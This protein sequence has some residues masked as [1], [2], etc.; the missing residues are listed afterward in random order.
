MDP[1]RYSELFH[2]EARE[3]LGTL[4]RLLLELERDPERPGVV[5]QLF[6]SVHTLKGSSAAMG[7]QS[8]SEV[9]H[10]LEELLARLRQGSLAI[11]PT[12]IDLLLQGADALERAIEHPEEGASAVVLDRLAAYVEAGAP[13]RTAAPASSA[14]PAATPDSGAPTSAGP[15]HRVKVRLESDTALPAVRATLVLRAA[16]SLGEVSQIQPPEASILAGELQGPFAFVIHGEATPEQIEAAV[17]S[18]GEVAEVEV[19]PLATTEGEPERTRPREDRTPRLGPIVR[20]P[21]SR[22]DALVDQVGELIIARDRLRRTVAEPAEADPELAESLEGVSRLIDDLREE[23]MR[24]RMVPVGEVFDRFPRMVRDAARRLDR[25][26]ELEI[27]GREEEV[28]RGLLNE[29]ADLLVHLLRNAV[30][31]GIEPPEERERAGK[32]RVGRIRL[33]AIREASMVRIEV[34]DDG[35]GLQRERILATAVK[36]GLIEA[37]DRHLSDQEIWALLTTPGFSTSERV[38]DV[39]GRGVGLDMVRT[40]AQALGGSLEV[41]SEAGKGA[42]FTLRIPL[43]LTLVRALR[44]EAGGAYYSVPLSGVVEVAELVD[45]DGHSLQVRGETLPALDLRVLFA[46]GS[47]SP[48][49]ENVAVVVVEFGG[50]KAGLIVAA[51]EGQHQAVVKPVD[52]PEGALPIFGGATILP[53]GRPSLILDPARTVAFATGRADLSARA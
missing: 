26:V 11:G 16:R 43:S 38:T 47:G 1:S 37:P 7:Y 24:L 5:E 23:I 42:T 6:R 18:A 44:F 14:G 30:D 53:D 12:T 29:V 33:S 19:N 22:L 28:D 48:G 8:A 36:R 45:Y 46:G 25:R 34:A 13:S 10:A 41:R 20:V 52:L 31:H 50:E 9:A 2:S 27:S 51:L 17:R 49:R 40:R 32:P 39:S 35:R 21:Q 15:A 4:T 3:H